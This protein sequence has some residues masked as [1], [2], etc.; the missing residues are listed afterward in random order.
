MLFRSAR[1]VR[2][3]HPS[4]RSAIDLTE[5]EASAAADSVAADPDRAAG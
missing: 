4:A 5:A 3:E 2:A 1:A